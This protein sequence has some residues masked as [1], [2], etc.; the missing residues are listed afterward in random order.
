VVLF[1]SRNIKLELEKTDIRFI[2]SH[3]MAKVIRKI[4]RISA[5][6]SPLTDYCLTQEYSKVEQWKIKY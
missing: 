1:S 4:N 2:D 6:D 3:K 5:F